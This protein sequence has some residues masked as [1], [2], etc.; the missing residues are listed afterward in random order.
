[1]GDVEKGEWVG[2][3]EG[4]VLGAKIAGKGKKNTNG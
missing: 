3:G 4:G 2:E 1:M